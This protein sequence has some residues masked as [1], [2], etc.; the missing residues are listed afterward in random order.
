MTKT[1]LKQQRSKEWKEINGWDLTPEQKS[2]KRAKRAIEAINEKLE[3]GQDASILID[4]F[5]EAFGYD[6][7][8]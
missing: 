5:I 3:K 2:E 7:L 8:Q 6:P 1:Q 4:L